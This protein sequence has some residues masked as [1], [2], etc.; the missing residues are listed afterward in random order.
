[1][2]VSLDTKSLE[3]KLL[4]ITQYSF[5][6]LDGID[7]GKTIFLEKFGE[8][9]IKVLQLYIDSQ[10]RS[11]PQSLHHVYEWYKTGSPSARL[12][13]ITQS[14]N[15]AGVSFSVS[16][17]QSTTLS[18]D[19]N[20]PFYD[21]ARVMEQGKTL[22]IAPKNGTTLSFNVD[23]EQIFT[24]NEVTV[25]NPG[26]DYVEGSFKDVMDEF[27]SSYFTQSFLRS[28]GLYEYLQKPTGYKHNLP[29]GAI[30][31]KIT[32]YE[33]GFKWITGARIGVE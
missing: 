1:M 27:F 19:S 31:G 23:G 26:G 10:A 6:F 24:K 15:R 5:G 7:G 29:A 12:F 25:E 20:E 32:G 8:G 3:K 21:K 28:S 33:T 30:K 9:V 11:N 4:N 2:K 16:F 17:T 13:D 14:V 22:R 18:N